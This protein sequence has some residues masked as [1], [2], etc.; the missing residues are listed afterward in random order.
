MAK[1]AAPR[2]AATKKTAGARPPATATHLKRGG[3]VL[4]EAEHA[5]E[6]QERKRK[7]SST[8]RFWL[9]RD[10]SID[11]RT[12]APKNQTGIIILDESI[13]DPEEQGLTT[14]VG[15]YEHT[16]KTGAKRFENVQ[17]CS[18]WD[19]CAIC[20]NGDDPCYV[21]MLSVFVLR[22]WTS[23]DGKRSGEGT[24]MLLP[25]KS[26]QL[27]TYCDIQRIALKNH[28]T[29]RGVFLFMERN[30]AN[31]QSA[32]IGEPTM[33]ENGALFDFYTEEELEAFSE[34]EVRSKDGKV[35]RPAGDNIQPFDYVDIFPMPEADKIRKRFGSG[36]QAGSYEEADDEWGAAEQPARSAPRRPAGRAR[37]QPAPAEDAGEEDGEY[38]EGQP[39]AGADPFAGEE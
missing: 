37:P 18:E 11:P 8:W 31:Q 16:V 10:T 23:K 4:K 21:V 32:A 28:G 24:K 7:Q 2:K 15:F 26:G 19:N 30:V 17:C 22:P 3:S 39:E 20:E 38:E 13:D 9:P 12:E 25:I 1:P 36:N 6:E 35:I 29:M 5:A 34:D 27:K 33:L 14:G